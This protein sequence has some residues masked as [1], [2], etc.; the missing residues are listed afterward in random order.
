LG[1]VKTRFPLET[2]F[3]DSG[4]IHLWRIRLDAAAGDA[5]E[6]CYRVL[7]AAERER[8][9]AYPD[10]QRRARFILSH[11]VTRLILG[12]YAGIAPE[13][14]AYGEQA[15]RKPVLA[16]PVAAS[17]IRFNLTHSEGIALL[18]V[19]PG[20]DVGV[21]IERIR[22]LRDALGLAQRFFAPEEINDLRSLSEPAE[23]EA[24][25]FRCWTRKEAMLKATGD[26][27]RFPLSAFAVTL[28]VGEAAAVRW[29]R[30]EPGLR[31]AWSLA[32]LEPADGYVG[33]LAH[34]G[35]ARPVR[36]FDWVAGRDI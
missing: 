26:G 20:L 8:A 6:W 5:P 2:G 14:V 19:A 9:A 33:A 34:C 32:S 1:S 22:S 18:A 13:E 25:F 17:D 11:G 15:N 3:L 12:R 10:E 29:D 36:L 35:E 30:R 31:G 16:G 23:R 28:L 7:D 21:D 4:E 27:L 24:A